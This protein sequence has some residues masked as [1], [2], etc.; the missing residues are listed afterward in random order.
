MTPA[1]NA[2]LLSQTDAAAARI[3]R[4]PERVSG[5]I[6]TIDGQFISGGIAEIVADDDG[7]RA[8]M[9]HLERPGLIASMYFTNGIREVVLRL[10]DGRSGVARITGTSFT[11]GSQRVCDLHGYDAL[12]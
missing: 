11:A 1:I 9:R 6:A 12:A 2:R 10:E 8:R 5:V 4:L 3:L 7:W